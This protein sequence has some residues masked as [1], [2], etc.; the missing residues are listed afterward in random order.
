MEKNEEKKEKKGISVSTL[1]IVVVLLI[2][3]IAP[4]SF[5]AGRSLASKEEKKEDNNVVDD[6]QNDGEEEIVLE[7][8]TV[9]S[10]VVKKLFEVFREDTI[11]CMG[12]LRAEVNTSMDARKYIAYMQ[13]NDTDFVEKTCGSLNDSYVDGN[14]CAENDDVW[15]YYG[16]NEQ[17]FE[18]TIKNE[19][20][21]TVSASLLEEKYREIFG[22]NADFE[23]GSFKRGLKHW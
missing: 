14:Y 4:I 18:E 11:N 23:N 19:T 21:K 9:D 15:Q 1:V 7:Q 2:A 13:L 12:D 17:K 5:M 16:V 20:T 6:E 8:L 22:Q 3:V 10:D